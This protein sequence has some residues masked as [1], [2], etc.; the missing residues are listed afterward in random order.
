MVG[1][2][3]V[4]GVRRRGASTGCVD[5]VRRRHAS[6]GRVEGRC[7]VSLGP[8]RSTAIIHN[9]WTLAVR[10][11]GGATLSGTS[12]AETGGCSGKRFGPPQDRPAMDHEDENLRPTRAGMDT[13]GLAN[14]FLDVY[15]LFSCC[16]A[17]TSVREWRITS[18][19]TV[20]LYK[21]PLFPKADVQSSRLSPISPSANDAKRPIM[22][23]LAQRLLLVAIQ[24]FTRPI[25]RTRF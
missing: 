1:G 16:L 10:D 8:S 21:C 17:T 22:A 9:A 6:T 13:E 2:R 12:T 18:P 25:F 5:R 19:K 7:E 11:H 24:P 4:D 3:R 23:I 15:H 14:D 20:S